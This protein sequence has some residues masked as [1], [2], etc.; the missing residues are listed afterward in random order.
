M[1]RPPAWQSPPGAYLAERNRCI[2]RELARRNLNQLGD[3]E[4]TSYP[5]DSPLLRLT[6]TAERYEYVMQRR[7]DIATACTR[8]PGEPEQ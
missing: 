3:P 6:D 7:R 1:E 4:G 8:A 2:D 5:A